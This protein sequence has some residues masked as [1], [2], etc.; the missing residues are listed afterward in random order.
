MKRLFYLQIA[1]ARTGEIA[2]FQERSLEVDFL[3]AAVSAILAKG[4]GV[5]RT[6]AQVEAAI[7]EGLD[8]TIYALKVQTKELV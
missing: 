7:R 5:F 6:Q 2:R 8:E 1:D 4:V 3:D